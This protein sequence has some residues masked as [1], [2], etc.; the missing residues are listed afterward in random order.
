MDLYKGVRSTKNDAIIITVG[1]LLAKQGD[2]ADA[3]L[4]VHVPK[5]DLSALFASS[6]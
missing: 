5:A 2:A 1:D 3:A 6:G 4:K